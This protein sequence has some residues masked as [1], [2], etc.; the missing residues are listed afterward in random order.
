[1][2]GRVVKVRCLTI[3][4]VLLA[5]CGS[6][7][8]AD[9]AESPPAPLPNFGVGDSYRFSDGNTESVVTID[10]DT[11]RWRG[12]GGTYVTSRDV[13]LPQLAW[14]N[15]SAQGERRIAAAS[16]LLFPLRPGKSVVFSAMRTVQGSAGGTP[17]TVRE[18]WQC[19]VSGTARLATAAGAFDT[20]RVDCTMSEQAGARDS[21]M[22]QRSLYYAPEIGFYVRR[23]ERTGDGP[24]Q[25]SELTSYT[26]AEPALPDSA[27]RVRI[28]GMQQALER[29]LSGEATPWHDPATGDAGEVLPVRTLR[30]TQYGWCRDFAESI[31]SA[32]RVYALQGTGCRNPSGV[33]D[34]VALAPVRTNNS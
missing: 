22:V 2:L 24:V 33:W 15:G 26:S 13:L 25:T 12:S 21:V 7:R 9:V 14:T 28:A 32:G 18:N 19:D 4:L 34:I 3:L 20:W 11:V 30:S 29:K 27:L 8:P 31:R 1:M 10:R 23:E 6:R 17:G 16:P 5:G